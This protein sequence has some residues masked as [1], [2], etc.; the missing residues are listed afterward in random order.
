VGEIAF[1]HKVVGLEDAVDVG[2]VDSDCN[3][4][5]HM[6]GTFS[7]AA[8]DAKEVGAFEGFETETDTKMSCQVQ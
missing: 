1:G 7:D 6:L 3:A 8:I 5:D 2:A 4:H